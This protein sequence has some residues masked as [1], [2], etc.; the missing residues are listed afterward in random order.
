MAIITVDGRS[1]ETEPGRN[2]L[3]VCLENDIYI[4]HLC[5]MEWL[6]PPHASCRLCYVEVEGRAGPVPSCTVSV[7]S[8]MAVKTDTEEVRSLQ[9]TALK[10]FLSAH[11]VECKVCPAN[12]QCPLQE[13]AKFLKVPLKS[14][15]LNPR[16]KEKDLE[17][18]Q[19]CFEYYPNRCVLCGKC[20]HTC[21]R[22]KGQ[23]LLTFAGRGI[24]MTVSFYGGLPNEEISC[25]ECAECAA[26]CPVKA[27][28]LVA[29]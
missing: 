25:E 5:F 16:L 17:A 13:M 24:D 21:E 9:R 28:L 4:P 27:I 26:V 18:L 29:G 6:D 1:I 20:V 8:G 12:R 3:E 19:P 10:F 15:D 11:K 2:L 23:S 7:A 22:V 14:K